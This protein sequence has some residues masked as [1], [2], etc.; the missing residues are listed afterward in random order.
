MKPIVYNEPLFRPP[1]EA[2]AL[3]IQVALGCTWNDCAFCEM[4]TSKKFT[5]RKQEDLFAEIDYAAQFADR[6]RKVFLADGNA[7]ALSNRR[8]LP[9][10]DKINQAFGRLKRISCYAMA[11]DFLKKSHEELVELRENGLTQA[12]IG[13]ESGDD[14]VLGFMN[15]QETADSTIEGLL[16]AKK[17][18]IKLS[19]IILNG[20][21]GK[22]YSE[23][24]AMGSAKVLNA[25]QPEFASVLVLSFPKGLEHFKKR[26]KANYEPL[27]VID[28]LKEVEV[29][30]QH[31]ELES[32]I[33]RSNHA[34]NYLALGGV[35]GRDKAAML[36]QL[37]VAIANPQLAN[38][39][40]E[41]AR[42]L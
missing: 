26:Y 35:L 4:Y 20:I 42:G 11:S 30:L 2:D 37:Q 36:N 12:Y 8:L 18:G 31:T 13:I 14:A 6:V 27:E 29:F 9:L 34:S 7:M 10:L 15:K 41:W 28:L 33:Y 1:S 23:Q 3:I 16:K 38:L 17:A 24:H 22:Q 39:R 40:P 19:V 21:G 25:V 32:T 5:V